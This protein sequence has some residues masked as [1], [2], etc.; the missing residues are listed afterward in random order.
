[1]ETLVYTGGV[2]ELAE[3]AAEI[4]E[5]RDQLDDAY[6][7]RADLI[8]EALNYGNSLRDIAE[9]MGV[10]HTAVRKAMRGR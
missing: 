1:V 3:I 10:S 8:T 5:L 4:E 6:A 7:R 9:V 2:V